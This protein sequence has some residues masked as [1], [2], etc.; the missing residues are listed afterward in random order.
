MTKKIII[1]L[2][3]VIVVAA[4]VLGSL[5]FIN[6]APVTSDSNKPTAQFDNSKDYGACTLV[7][8]ALIGKA[9]GDV[10]ATLQQPQSTGIV[11][12]KSIGDNV[13]NVAS[14]SQTCIYAFKPGGSADN[15]FNANDA[16]VVQVTSYSSDSDTKSVI[17]QIKLDGT[18]SALNVGDST[19][20]YSSNTVSQGPGATYHFKLI[21]IKGTKQ[22]ALSINQPAGS[23]SVAADAAKTALYEIASSI[24]LP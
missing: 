11:S 8:R 16:F 5:Y 22:Y 24:S 14:D 13:K 4:A 2:G 3:I 10:A 18:I 15:G 1:G 7:D 12:N 21:I 20:F 19:A 17:E 9:L 23:G 6:R